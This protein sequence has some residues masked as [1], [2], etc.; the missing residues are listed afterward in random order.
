MDFTEFHTIGERIEQQDEQLQ[1]AK[2]YDH[3]WVL[4]KSK[5][6]SSILPLAATAIEPTSGRVLEVFS[7][8]LHLLF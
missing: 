8:S 6:E 4:Q 1:I 3:N 5:E 7:R 2:G